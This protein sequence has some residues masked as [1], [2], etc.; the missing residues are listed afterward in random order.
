M[1]L[2]CAQSVTA[3]R[4]GTLWNPGSSPAAALPAPPC[5]ACTLRFLST[6][7]SSDSANPLAPACYLQFKLSITE[8]RKAEEAAAAELAAQR[9]AKREAAQDKAEAVRR[10]QMRHVLFTQPEV[11]EVRL[12]GMMPW[13]NGVST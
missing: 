9:R 12:G 4:S 6:A 5:L 11:P 1:R 8:Q 7:A 13:A 10:K 3:M 2:G